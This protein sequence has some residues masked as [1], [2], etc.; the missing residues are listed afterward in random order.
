MEQ[1]LE[2]LRKLINKIAAEHKYK[3]H[4][5]IINE[6][7]SGG[8][9]YSS[10]LFTVIIRE[11][12]KE[13]IHLFAKVAAFAAEAR[14]EMP[15]IDVDL[16][17]FAYTKL[18]K[19]YAALEEENGVPEEHRLFFAKLYGHNDIK[20]QEI[21]ILENLLARGYKPFN[22]FKSYDWEYASTAVKDLAKFHALSFAF[23]NKDPEEFEKTVATIKIDWANSDFMNNINK[24]MVKTALDNVNPEYKNALEKFLEDKPLPF[25]M[26]GAINRPAIVHGDF[27][28]DN[29]VH[30]IRE[31][32]SF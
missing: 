26:T 18:S 17:L 16:E 24:N 13:D 5:I 9:N 25:T 10:Q 15:K 12:N 6:L 8:A 29:L 11:A 3:N 22:R 7:S 2:A 30:R 14:E 28:G 31:V 23:G 27:R 21:L 19:I 1:K 20:N 32:R 4:E